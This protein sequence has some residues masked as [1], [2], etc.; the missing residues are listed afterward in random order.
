[1]LLRMWAST[2]F[3]P[4]SP[5]P[6]VI[7]ATHSLTGL[8]LRTLLTSGMTNRARPR[9]AARLSD[10]GAGPVA[11]RFGPCRFG[12]RC[13]APVAGRGRHRAADHF[14]RGCHQEA[15]Q[16]PACKP[17]AVL[18]GARGAEPAEGG[19]MP[20]DAHTRRTPC[21]LPSVPKGTEGMPPRRGA[22]FLRWPWRFWCV[23]L[24][25]TAGGTRVCVKGAGI[26]PLAAAR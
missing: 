16:G 4:A 10:T 23:R 5:G 15:S 9:W 14:V 19:W 20:L 7:Q 22:F 26:G 25:A 6:A 13:K 11:S 1:M 21:R 8:H 24:A 12:I 17:A 18:P 2:G 3:H